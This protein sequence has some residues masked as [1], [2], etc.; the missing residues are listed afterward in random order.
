M[1]IGLYVTLATTGARV[2]TGELP[3]DLSGMGND[4]EDVRLNVQR[5]VAALVDDLFRRLAVPP[6]PVAAS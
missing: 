1:N 6:Q 5:L 3:L 2:L 4:P